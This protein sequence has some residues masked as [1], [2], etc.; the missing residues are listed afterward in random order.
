MVGASEFESKK[1]DRAKRFGAGGIAE[2]DEKL[3]MRA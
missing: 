1:L 3:K 2:D